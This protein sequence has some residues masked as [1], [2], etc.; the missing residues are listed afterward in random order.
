MREEGDS[1][2]FKDDFLRMEAEGKLGLRWGSNSVG[3]M[4]HSFHSLSQRYILLQV[5]SV[6]PHPNRYVQLVLVSLVP[7]GLSQCDARIPHS[8]SSARLRF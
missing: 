1:E 5:S 4:P 6:H 8:L 3:W 7:P 2:D